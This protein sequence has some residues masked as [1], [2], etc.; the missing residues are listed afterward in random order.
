MKDLSVI[1]HTHNEE[2]NIRD[3]IRSI[4]KIAGEVIV[5]DMQSEDKTVVLARK[6]GAKVYS[7]RKYGYAD[8]VRNFGISKTKKKWVLVLDADER[9]TTS[10][11]K[12]ISSIIENDE[13]DVV[14]LP[15]RNIMFNKWIKHASWWPDYQTRLFKRGKVKWSSAVHTHPEA[16]GKVLILEPQEDNAIEHR[17]LKWY[18]DADGLFDM[19]KT[20]AKLTDF[21]TSILNKSDL[22]PTDLFNYMT[23]E[24]KFRFIQNE[25]YLDNMHG[26]ILSKLMEFYRFAEIVYFWEKKGY[27]EMFNNNDLKQA[28]EKMLNN[29]TQSAV[30]QL[31]KIEA[32]KFYKLWRFYCKLKEFFKQKK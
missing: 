24:F 18:K 32:S 21:E 20:Y 9:I 3:C 23:G 19:I 12:K 4:K 5:V 29:E 15:R 28:A 30:L 16:L 27:P 6:S 31:Q 10:L 14:K 22:S 7:V 2:R 11:Q 8:P 25:G 13:F 26:F 1:I 17:N